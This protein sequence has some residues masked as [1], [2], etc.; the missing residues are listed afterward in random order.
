MVPGDR[1]FCAFVDS[2]EAGD[3]FSD[4]PLHLTIV[5]WFR[6]ATSSE[7]LGGE[8]RRRLQWLG[9]FQV[10]VE[11]EAKFGAKRRLV[12]LVAEP[13]PLRSIEHEVREMLHEHAAWLV[14][15]TTRV[16]RPFRPHVT[17]QRSGRLQDGDAFMCEA[18]YIVEQKGG[19]KEVV[20][21]IRL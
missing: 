15:E 2:R 13:T 12:S 16:R 18:L 10:V 1:L 6:T 14:D 17:A 8:L 9:P 19:Y 21:K 20:N 7:E 4:W 11:G 5:P 3:T